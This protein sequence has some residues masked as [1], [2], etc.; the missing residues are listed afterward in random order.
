MRLLRDAIVYFLVVFAAGWVLGPIRVFFVAPQVGA[1]TA[2]SMETPL[3]ILISWLAA[4]RVFAGGYEANALAVAGLVS[5]LLLVGGEYAGAALLRGQSPGMF[6]SSFF[7]AEGFI[8][9]DGFLA[10]GLMPILAA[11]W[12]RFTPG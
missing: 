10:Y 6:L 9:L 3:M 2:V 1:L 7:S 5:L 12:S 4:R 8:T 11:R